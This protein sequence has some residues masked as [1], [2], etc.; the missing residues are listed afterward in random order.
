MWWIESLKVLLSGVL[1][2]LLVFW[3]NTSYNNAKEKAHYKN[4]VTIVNLEIYTNY[5]RMIYYED[6]KYTL[7]PIGFRTNDWDRVKIEIA[8]RLPQSL[9]T[10]LV[11]T[12]SELDSNKDLTMDAMLNY[13][14]RIKSDLI[15]LAK[16]L[17]KESKLVLEEISEESITKAFEAVSQKH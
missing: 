15:E 5:L 13:W 16:R 14:L 7:L 8:K 9:F 11:A 17:N 4:L 1:T 10:D 12:Y 3:L 6:K 2:A